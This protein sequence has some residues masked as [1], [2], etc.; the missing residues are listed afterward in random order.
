MANEASVSLLETQA[1]WV[2]IVTFTISLVYEVWR[3]TARA[4]VSR[5]DSIRVFFTQGFVI[6]VLA[7]VVIFLLFAG[8]AAAPWV[9]LVFTLVAILVSLFYYNPTVL[10]ERKPGLIDW[11]EDLV[12]TG[13]LFVAAALLINEVLGKSLV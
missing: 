11:L 5:H 10:M 9:A 7:A 12:F 1:A 13:L 8:V 2:L 6:Y 3:A 4:G